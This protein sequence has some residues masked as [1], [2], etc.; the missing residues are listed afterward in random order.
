M[1]DRCSS[2]L[3]LQEFTVVRAWAQRRNMMNS[4]PM[5]QAIYDI[6]CGP[7]DREGD[8]L[9]VSGHLLKQDRGLCRLARTE[10]PTG[11]SCLRGYGGSP[12][13]KES[14]RGYGGSPLDKASFRSGPKRAAN[15]GKWQAGA[16]T[17]RLESSPAATEKKQKE[18]SA[19]KAAT[20]AAAAALDI[21]SGDNTAQDSSK[22]VAA[23]PAS[24]AWPPF[25]QPARQPEPPASHPST[26]PA[27]Q[28]VL[29]RKHWG[30]IHSDCLKRQRAEAGSGEP[31]T[32]R[33]LPSFQVVGGSRLM[34][35]SA[36]STLVRH[37]RSVL[38][39]NLVESGWAGGWLVP[40]I[41]VCGCRCQSSLASEGHICV[42]SEK[43]GRSRSEPI[44]SAI[45]RGS[46][47]PW[48]HKC[49]PP[50]TPREPDPTSLWAL[51]SMRIEIERGAREAERWLCRILRRASA[52][53]GRVHSPNG[54][55]S[56][57]AASRTTTTTT[58]IGRVTEPDMTGHRSSPPTSITKLGIMMGGGLD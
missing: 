4:N 23:A 36:L 22:N 19:K 1:L 44:P 49:D 15:L 26:H 39:V 56:L 50:A 48:R 18:R 55:R 27:G 53:V 35:K 58:P 43:R 20:A 31:A 38:C 30:K 10:K 47:A 29:N 33:S 3:A 7:Y 12:L 21:Q 52:L 41:P 32:S 9:R 24:P 13:D 16:W 5:R 17:R 54:L 14:Y 51:P 28:L 37:S 11:Q 25:S 8:G 2:V 34:E 42:P 57:A 45:G 6:I 46:A 40:L